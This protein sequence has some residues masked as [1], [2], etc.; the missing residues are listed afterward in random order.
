MLDLR[1]SWEIPRTDF[2]FLNV[3]ILAVKK[4]G[5]LQETWVLQSVKLQKKNLCMWCD[6]ASSPTFLPWTPLDILHPVQCCSIWMLKNPADEHW[7]SGQIIFSSI[8]ADHG[9]N[10]NIHRNCFECKLLMKIC[11]KIRKLNFET[12]IFCFH[13]C[14]STKYVHMKHVLTSINCHKEKNFFQ[15]TLDSIFCFM[16]AHRRIFCCCVSVEWTFEK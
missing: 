2:V 12:L 8:V 1:K 6:D 4:I 7:G 11:G 13:C 15:K 14:F 3:V 9:K 16:Q 10:E 5:G